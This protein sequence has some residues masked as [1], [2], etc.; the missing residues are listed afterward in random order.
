MKIKQSMVLAILIASQ[1]SE[2]KAQSNSGTIDPRNIFQNAIP[3]GPDVAMQA[4]YSMCPPN[5]SNGLPQ[6]NI[7]LYTYAVR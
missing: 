7:P 5:Y 3:A 1:F 2:L 4:R 6:Q